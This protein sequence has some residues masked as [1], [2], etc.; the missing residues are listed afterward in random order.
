MS[1]FLAG[2][3]GRGGGR[4]LRQYVYRE[5]IAVADGSQ[6]IAAALRGATARQ[7]T[8]MRRTAG[9]ASR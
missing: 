9:P 3:L 5:L 4:K 1:L 2:F 8:T 7:L 6:A